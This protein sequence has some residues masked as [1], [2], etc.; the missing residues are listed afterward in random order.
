[1]ASLAAKVFAITGGASGMGLAIAK[2]LA[3][4]NAKAVCIADFNTANFRLSS[5]R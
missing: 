5:S 2:R 4:L 3:K 1:M